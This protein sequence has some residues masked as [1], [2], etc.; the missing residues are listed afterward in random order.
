MDPST[1]KKPEKIPPNTPVY[2]A[3]ENVFAYN[4]DNSKTP[5]GLK[6]RFKIRVETGTKARHWDA[7]QNAAIRE[8]L[9]WAHHRQAPHQPSQPPPPP[10]Q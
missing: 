1:G 6:V 5:R 10:S 9:L 4:L 8:L 2:I 3:A 7:K